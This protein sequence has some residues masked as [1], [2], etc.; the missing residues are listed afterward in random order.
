[1]QYANDQYVFGSLL[2]VKTIHCYVKVEIKIK[3]VP[4]DLLNG[5]KY[6]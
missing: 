1:M 5:F 2:F 6:Y 4:T 3:Y